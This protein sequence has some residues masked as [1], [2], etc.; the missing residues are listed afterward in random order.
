MLLALQ[1]M[2][3]VAGGASPLS[4]FPNK[5]GSVLLHVL[6]C[7]GVDAPLA[8]RGGEVRSWCCRF[9]DGL[10][11]V[12]VGFVLQQFWDLCGGAVE[13]AVQL[14]KLQRMEEA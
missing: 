11:G 2:E 4:P 9:A 1:W 10:D 3:T 7:G 13:I 12:G 8:G 6:R 5:L 14:A